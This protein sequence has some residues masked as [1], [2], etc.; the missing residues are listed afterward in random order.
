[1]IL[2]W[3]AREDSCLLR[4][5]PP[6]FRGDLEREIDLVEEIARMNGYEKIPVTLPKGPPAVSSEEKSKESVAEKRVV[7]LAE[8]DENGHFKR[9]IIKTLD[10]NKYHV[11]IAK[12]FL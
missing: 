10:P 12:F 7:D 3:S 11:D 8:T 5:I 9:N 2:T 4:V 1:V 6:S